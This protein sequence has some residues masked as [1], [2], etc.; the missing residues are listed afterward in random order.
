MQ[1]LSGNRMKNSS[2]CK[3]FGIK[4]KNAAQTSNVIRAALNEKKIKLADP[5]R[6]RGGYIP[7]KA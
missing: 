2:L 3:R 7:W 4:P 1:Y 5:E 6:P